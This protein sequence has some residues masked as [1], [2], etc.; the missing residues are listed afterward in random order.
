MVGNH[1]SDNV[2]SKISIKCKVHL[3]ILSF[4]LII[5]DSIKL[6]KQKTPIKK[7]CH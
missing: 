2:T 7:V 4:K 1:F 5:S 6:Q 3:S